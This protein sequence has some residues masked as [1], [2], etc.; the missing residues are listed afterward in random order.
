MKGISLGVLEHVHGMIDRVL[1]LLKTD[2]DFWKE[3]AELR[4]H[5]ISR[6]EFVSVLTQ[7]RACSLPQVFGIATQRGRAGWCFSVNFAM[8]STRKVWCDLP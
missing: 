7:A 6:F 5:A 4:S 8:Q 1:E 3:F 2:D